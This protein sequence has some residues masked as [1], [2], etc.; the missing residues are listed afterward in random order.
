MSFKHLLNDENVEHYRASLPPQDWS[1]LNTY[2]RFV[3]SNNVSIHVD[4]AAY[5]IDPSL[6]AWDP[7]FDGTLAPIAF[8]ED[9]DVQDSYGINLNLDPASI[10]YGEEPSEHPP[11]TS[12]VD[13]DPAQLEHVCYGTICRVPIKLLGDMQAL[14]NKLTTGT[15]SPIAGHLQLR[16]IKSESQYLVAFPDDVVFGEVNVQLERALTNLAEQQ[17]QLEFEVFVPVR[18]TRETITKATRGQEAVVRVQMNLY[19][20]RAWADSVGQELSHNKVYLQRPDYVREGVE[21]D[22]PHVLKFSDTSEA[23]PFTLITADEPNDNKPTDQSFK[24]VI[25]DVYSSL[26]RNERLKG[27]EG[28]EGLRTT[29]LR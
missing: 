1:D 20:I 29:L 14:D 11:F 27:L 24:Q 22:N 3:W 5:S 9:F 10:Q 6:S 7:Y 8:A 18:A 26:T 25:N 16:L 17:L 12:G 4:A 28:H 19:G 23:V 15:S 2:G 13:D 21:Y